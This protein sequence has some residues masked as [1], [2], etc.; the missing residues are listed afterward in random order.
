MS[1]ITSNNIFKNKK[2]ENILKVLDAYSGGLEFK[3]IAY[4]LL[5]EKRLI[6]EKYIS[7]ETASDIEEYLCK[8]KEY[9]IS[10]DV[11]KNVQR[12]AECLDRLEKLGFIQITQ[13]KNKTI[14]KYQPTHLLKAISTAKKTSDIQGELFSNLSR[15]TETKRILMDISKQMEVYVSSEYA[16]KYKNS[17]KVNEAIKRFQSEVTILL[18]ELET[19]SKESHELWKEKDY[20]SWVDLKP[21]LTI[22]I[23][24][25]PI[26]SEEFLFDTKELSGKIKE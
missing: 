2:Y 15:L 21:F 12:L 6:D 5:G 22:V 11:P 4:A 9:Q 10:N 26:N 19:L 24:F 1:K 25:P 17:K 3:H 23:H 16:G 18:R 20:C 8:S 14:K 7:K 13:E